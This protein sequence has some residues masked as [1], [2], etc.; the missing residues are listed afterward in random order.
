MSLSLGRCQEDVSSNQQIRPPKDEDQDLYTL[1]SQYGAYDD[2]TG[3]FKAIRIAAVIKKAIQFGYIKEGWRVVDY[4]RHTAV[5]SPDDPVQRQGFED[6]L[7]WG[8]P[9]TGKSNLNLQILY[10][11]FQDWNEVLNHTI[12]TKDQLYEVYRMTTEEQVRIPVLLMDDI[13][14][15]IPKQLYFLAMKEFVRLQQFIA[16]IRPRIGT[17]MSN[18]P[19]PQ[20][21]I[22]ILRDMIT[23]EIIVFPNFSYMV[24]RY[25]WFPD[26]KKAATAYLQKVVTEFHSWDMYQIPKDVWNIYNERRWHITE[27]IVKQLQ[28]KNA[29]EGDERDREVKEI[30]KDLSLGKIIERVRAKGMRVDE[31]KARPFLEA[32]KE[33]AIQMYDEEKKKQLEQL[34]STV[35]VKKHDQIVEVFETVK[36]KA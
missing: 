12:M 6:V 9:G 28:E 23:I 29:L 31:R 1:N 21:L 27:E 36:A 33:I 4:I 14:T 15:T 10:S 26:Q 18:S 32:A 5:P 19:L 20:N 17:L 13:T 11:L 25:C 16:T 34:A 8:Q 30:I 22:S 7:T 35:D 3:K 2:E 24:E